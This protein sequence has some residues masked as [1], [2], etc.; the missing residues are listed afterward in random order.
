MH[1]AQW[2][3]A[4]VLAIALHLAALA[5]VIAAWSNAV[6]NQSESE[7]VT[8]SLS[9]L[10]GPSKVVAATPSQPA[11]TP[12]S[13]PASAAS[14]TTPQTA[15][16]K[17]AKSPS[18]EAVTP[19]PTNAN[20]VNVP[21]IQAHSDVAA[22]QPGQPETPTDQKQARPKPE[23][24]TSR[25]TA[26]EPTH[27]TDAPVPQSLQAVNAQRVKV[28]KADSSA[29]A[30]NSR[31][32]ASAVHKALAAHKIYP[33]EARRQDIQGRV[34]VRLVIDQSGELIRVS[35]AQSS[36]YTVLD[37]AAIKTVKAAAPFSPI[38]SSMGRTRVA[39]TLPY[40]YGLRDN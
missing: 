23:A 29:H 25:T 24:G 11:D 35:V 37:Q 1:P 39:Y 33:L 9:N 21:T 13:T 32:Y 4:F 2:L 34:W 6:P 36:G 14:S 31:N 40:N 26:K 16:P 8:I 7:G 27:V 5:L 28:G 3:L 12:Q 18:A 30:A 20:S 10:G 38:P 17:P 19:Q 22:T 15:A